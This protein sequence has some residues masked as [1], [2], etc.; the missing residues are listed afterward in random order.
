ML[1]L[2]ILAKEKER[3]KGTKNLSFLSQTELLKF[4]ILRHWNMSLGGWSSSLSNFTASTLVATKCLLL[5]LM[6]FALV[7]KV[8]QPMI[9][10]YYVH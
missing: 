2:V 8:Q 6:L 3:K 9:V 4:A 5:G 7:L 1:G 10:V